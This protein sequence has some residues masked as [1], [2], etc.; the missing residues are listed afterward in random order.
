MAQFLNIINL[1]PKKKKGETSDT[2]K[3]IDK[4]NKSIKIRM[5]KLSAAA[6]LLSRE[7]QQGKPFLWRFSQ[8]GEAVLYSFTIAAKKI[9]PPLEEQV[10]Y[11]C[12]S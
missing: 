9:F 8:K 2:E 7:M 11:Y 10:K 3:S 4:K 5:G 12:E 1:L 6:I